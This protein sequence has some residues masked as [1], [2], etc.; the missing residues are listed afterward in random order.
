MHAK[1]F[2]LGTRVRD[3][4]TGFEGTLVSHCEH[5]HMANEVGILPDPQQPN[6]VPQAQWF[7]ESRIVA[8]GD[9]DVVG[10]E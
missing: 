8:A 9:A 6:H 10:Q 3:M 7:Q 1:K 2:P 4:V 5:L